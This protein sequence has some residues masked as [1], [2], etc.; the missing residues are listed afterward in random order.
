MAWVFAGSPVADIDAVIAR[1][2]AE[3]R[4]EDRLLLE[5]KPILA[6]ARAEGVRAV[7]VSASPE[8][9]VFQAAL[10]WGFEPDDIVAARARIRA[11]RYTVGLE[12]PLPYEEQKVIAARA[13]L[14]DVNWLA[15]FGNS[16]FDLHM[17][18]AARLAVAVQPKADLYAGLSDVPHAVVLDSSSTG[19][20]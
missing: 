14:G 18:R 16:L 4:L 10:L 17:L 3:R 13:L 11:G 7:V 5:M 1:A 20:T 19:S 8:R 9:V 12:A 6:W 2:L 15:A